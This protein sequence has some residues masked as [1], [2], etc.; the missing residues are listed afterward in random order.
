MSLGADMGDGFGHSLLRA[1]VV[2]G[3]TLDL[4]Q[5]L[6]VERSADAVRRGSQ[7]GHARPLGGVP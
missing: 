7:L 3:D 2:T 6:S 4:S 5:K 1:V